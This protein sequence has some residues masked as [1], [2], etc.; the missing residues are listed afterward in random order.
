MRSTKIIYWITTGLVFLMQGLMP[1]FMIKNPDGI[2]AFTH[3]GYPIY[4][5]TMLAIFKLIGGL[6]L[7]IPQV[8]TRFK[9]WAYAGFGIDFIAA[10]ASF[11]AVDGFTATTLFPLAFLVILGV[12]YWAYHKMKESHS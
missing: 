4:F 2:A 11:I 6:A 8:P 10:A 7:I 3:L 9:E 1:I 5:I 12:S